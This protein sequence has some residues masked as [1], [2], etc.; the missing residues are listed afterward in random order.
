[1]TNVTKLRAM[2]TMPE[3]ERP[4]HSV[5]ADDLVAAGKRLRDTVPRASQGEWKRPRDRRDPL[6]ILQAS[7]EGRQTHLLPI[8]YGRLL[9]SPFTFYRG[10]AAVMAADLA[11]TPSTGVHV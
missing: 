4:V 11:A 8:R 5:P 1:M 6:E 3:L 2:P 10:A 7:D 9:Q